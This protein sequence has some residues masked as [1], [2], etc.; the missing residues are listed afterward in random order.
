MAFVEHFC[1]LLFALL[2]EDRLRFLQPLLDAVSD[3]LL[4]LLEAYGVFGSHVVC[5]VLQ[6]TDGPI[7][8][9][10]LVVEKVVAFALDAT[11][12]F[13]NLH[14]LFPRWLLH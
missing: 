10:L 12:R 7:L 11:K 2:Q 13:F 3:D 14:L 4:L 8:P 1:C 6:L 5:Y 9:L